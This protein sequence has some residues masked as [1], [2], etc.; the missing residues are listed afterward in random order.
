MAP[1]FFSS[2][3]VPT[4]FLGMLAVSTL[5]FLLLSLRTQ[6]PLYRA[7]LLTSAAGLASIAAQIAGLAALAFSERL[8]IVV[9]LYR[10]EQIVV[11]LYLV[12]M[13]LLL[14]SIVRLSRWQ[15]R[16]NHGLLVGM[17]AACGAILLVAFLAPELFVSIST[18]SIVAA[19]GGAAFSPAMRRTDA[20]YV[21]VARDAFL[22]L[23]AL[24]TIAALLRNL[25]KENLRTVLPVTLGLIL[26]M[27]AG[28]DDLWMIYFARSFLLPGFLDLQRLPIGM[29][30]FTLCAVGAGFATYLSNAS[31]VA[32]MRDRLSDMAYNDHLTGLQ[33]RHSFVERMKQV[34][35]RP[36]DEI[37]TRSVAILVLDLDRFKD[38]NDS[39]G[40]EVG[41]QML[42]EVRDRLATR[43]RTGDELYR[44]G[45]DEFAIVL[46][47]VQENSQAA[48]VARK[49]IEALQ[50]PFVVGERMLYTGVTIGIAMHPGDGLTGDTLMR[51]ADVALARAKEDR[52]TYR[53]YL[54]DMQKESLTKVR[55]AS[56]LRNSIASNELQVFYQPQ[57]N[58]DGI[59]FAAE[60]LL[61]WHNGQLGSIA[62]SQFI[63]IAEEHGLIVPMG[64]WVLQQV[65]R[66]YHTI[67]ADLGAPVPISV[68]VSTKQLKDP[69]F[70]QFV[71]ST[72]SEYGLDAGAIHLEITE[73][74][75]ME[76]SSLIQ[77]TMNELISAGIEF[78]I[79]DFGVGY[80]SLSYLRS[81]PVSTVKLD[82]S[83]I[84][85]VP[86]NEQDSKL[87][88]ALIALINELKLDMVAEGVEDNEQ[89]VFLSATGC[90]RLQGYFF[91][92]PLPLGEFIRYLGDESGDQEDNYRSETGTRSAGKA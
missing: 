56:E 19:D 17:L 34:C 13:P 76:Q 16:M 75:L 90:R 6:E 14:E 92:R 8:D 64:E 55:I 63:P 62:P 58:A 5:V 83:F 31:A 25:R 67:M 20:G 29:T 10:L 77:T 15:R 73:S 71:L 50:I 66:D 39:V 72:L 81:L 87:V 54:E 47:D 12:C 57:C 26:A 2:I 79:D 18:D 3:I 23:I 88:R 74:A 37:Q 53:F 46:P 30:I 33:N 52:N 44:I 4:L 78:E 36:A 65:C 11:S 68:N 49:L 21:R 91:S 61:R 82:R 38:I 89:R 27:V 80:S 70:G 35:S 84:R 60:A 28:I 45:G 1:G 59:P 86:W 9:Q 32:R 7:L 51:H 69:G 22:A 42:L 24:F 40:H 48:A 85:N 43:I 41:D